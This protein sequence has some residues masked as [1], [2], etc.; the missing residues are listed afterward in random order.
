M[1]RV[2]HNTRERQVFVNKGGGGEGG[3]KKK[4]K[5]GNPHLGMVAKEADG[6]V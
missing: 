6:I 5:F 2:I 3:R 4:L 1:R